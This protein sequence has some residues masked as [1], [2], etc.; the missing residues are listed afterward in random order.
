VT[1]VREAAQLADALEDLGA[2]GFELARELRH[3][4]E[5]RGV[6]AREVAHGP[7]AGAAAGRFLGAQETL[8]RVLRDHV[9][10]T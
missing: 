3:W 5:W 9:G 1:N 4:H 8:C 10:A 6:S 7:L 2:R